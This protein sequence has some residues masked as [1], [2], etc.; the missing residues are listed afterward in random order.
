MRNCNKER[1][2]GDI[3]PQKWLT[4][5]AMGCAYSMLLALLCVACSREEELYQALMLT[6]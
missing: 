6:S 2:C 1:T 5:V 3:T 4:K